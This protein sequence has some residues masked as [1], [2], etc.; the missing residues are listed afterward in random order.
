M[1]VTFPSFGGRSQRAKPRLMGYQGVQGRR[2]A[3][4]A[5]WPPSNLWPFDSSELCGTLVLCHSSF[6]R[7]PAPLWGALAP[8]GSQALWSFVTPAFN[9]HPR[10]SGAPWPT[11]APR[12]FGP[13]PLQLLKHTPRTSAPGGRAAPCTL[14][15]N[16]GATRATRPGAASL[17][18][19]P[20]ADLAP[21]D[22]P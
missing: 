7:S 17:P 1:I 22:I 4:R 9:A 18:C 13:L 10:P 5:G 20:G 19:P 21:L 2:Q 3:G 6:Q 15:I 14:A 12:H 16:N 11:R 8:P